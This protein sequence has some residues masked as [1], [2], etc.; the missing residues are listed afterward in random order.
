MNYF[1]SQPTNQ[2]SENN[3]IHNIIN[4]EQ[5]QDQELVQDQEHDQ[6]KIIK[7]SSFNS[8]RGKQIKKTDKFLTKEISISNIIELKEKN[9]IIIPT[10]QRLVDQNKIDKMIKSYKDNP[11]Y[12]NFLTNP[13]QL[14]KLFE[15]ESD[16]EL[17]YLIDGQHR[18][19]MYQQLYKEKIN[20]LLF[21]NIIN[22]SSIEEMQKIYMNFNIDNKNIYFNFDEIKDRQSFD[23]NIYLRDQLYKLYKDNFKIRDDNLYSVEEFVK[24][25]TDISLLDYFDTINDMKQFIKDRNDIFYD[26]FY[27]QA[28]IETFLCKEKKMIQTTI[29]FTLKNN[30]FIDFMMCNDEDITDFEYSHKIIKKTN[31]I[32]SK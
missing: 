7:K 30:N 31:I 15:I 12:F 9:I 27:K 6:E 8:I 20:N 22:C 29:I 11:D 18:I 25:I 13:I 32:K 16:T 19:C 2:V 26:N 10:F 17:L 23:K 3:A 5:D 24:K 21:I 14:V 1:F 28:N 4:Q